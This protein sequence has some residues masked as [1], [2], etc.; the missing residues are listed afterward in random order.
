MNHSSVCLFVLF[1]LYSKRIQYDRLYFVI[2][3]NILYDILTFSMLP[4]TLYSIKFVVFLLFITTA[5]GRNSSPR[6][7]KLW[8]HLAD[9]IHENRDDKYG[10]DTRH[11][12]KEGML[13]FPDVAFQSLTDANKWKIVLHGWRYKSSKREDWFGFSTSLWIKRL[14]RNLI[15]ENDILYLNGTISRDRLRPFFVK[16]RLDESITITLGNTTHLLNTDHYGEFYEQIE[17]TNSDLQKLKQQQ[18][19]DGV[20]K[21]E[22]SG[23][24]EEKLS[25]TIRLI[26]PSQGISVISDIDDT[27][28]ISEVLDKVRLLANTFIFP[29]KAVSGKQKIEEILFFYSFYF[30][31]MPE[32][33][34]QWKSKNPNCMFHY[35]SGMPDQLYTLTQEFINTNK[36]PDG[37]FHMRHFG[38]AAA[39]LFD[40]LHSQSTF[41]H[42]MSYLHFFLSSTSRDYIL[43][44]DSGEKDPEIYGTITREYPTR[45]RAIFIRAIQGEK[46]DDQRFI[47]AFQG[48]PQEKWLIFND[49]KQVPLD[50]SKSP[51]LVTG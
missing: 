25:G 29:F 15:N 10:V 18:H 7:R 27:I 34:Q 12:G 23:S 40:F 32:L 22:A 33:Y 38:W 13:L 44:G 51:R 50:L 36:F 4:V 28:K 31:G 46:F 21:Y 35:L 2:V 49:P 43:I 45:I 39:S 41:T 1:S 5:E 11:F 16:D 48:V 3:L 17:I 19:G 14:A 37:S 8:H 26:E 20:I 42:K 24:D 47:D 30:I 9:K 6:I